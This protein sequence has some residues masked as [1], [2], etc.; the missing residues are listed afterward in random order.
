LYIRRQQNLLPLMQKGVQKLGVRQ[1]GLPP[2]LKELL[3][4]SSPLN[5]WENVV[6]MTGLLNAEFTHKVQG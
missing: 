4:G 5:T 6:T 3:A 2:V 1:Q